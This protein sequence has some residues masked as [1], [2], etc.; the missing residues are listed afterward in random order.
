MRNELYL[1]ASRST[2]L[3]ISGKHPLNRVLYVPTSEIN[4]THDDRLS[5]I[6][7]HVDKY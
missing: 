5:L 3:V 4:Y 1:P 7:R 6:C 2:S